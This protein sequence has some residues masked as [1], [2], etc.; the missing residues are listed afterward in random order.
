MQNKK[1]H[2]TEKLQIIT[3]WQRSGLS[4]KAFCVTNNI[5]YHV[6]H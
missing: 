6:F 3:Q 2:R 4:Q 5:A 1:K